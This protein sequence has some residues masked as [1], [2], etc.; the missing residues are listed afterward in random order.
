M[1]GSY[2]QRNMCKFMKRHRSSFPY[3]IF[4]LL[5]VNQFSISQSMLWLSCRKVEALTLSQKNKKEIH[6]QTNSSDI[7]NTAGCNPANNVI[8]NNNMVNVSW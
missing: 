7:S 1:F 6:E 3:A 5:H 8:I 2:T 4:S